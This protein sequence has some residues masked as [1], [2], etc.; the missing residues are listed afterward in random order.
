MYRLLDN[1]KAL[2]AVAIAIAFVA[3]VIPTCRMVGCSMDMGSMGSMGMVHM[4]TGLG[5]SPS[6]DG[7]LSTTQGPLAV[8]PLGAEVLVLV[9]MAALTVGTMFF[10][11]HT[12][13]RLVLVPDATPP[14][15]PEDPL[16]ERFR[17]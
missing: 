6:C 17:V 13:S 4:G 12:V 9:L 1:R 3:V 10:S 2:I 5:M 8:V 14:P 7:E 16:G 15:P 11:P